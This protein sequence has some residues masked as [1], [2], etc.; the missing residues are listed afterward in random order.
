MM[1]CLSHLCACMY[2]CAQDLSSS[3][4]LQLRIYSAPPACAGA[5]ERR[6]RCKC[7]RR[8]VC[9]CMCESLETD[10]CTYVAHETNRPLGQYAMKFTNKIGSRRCWHKTCTFPCLLKRPCVTSPDK[11]TGDRRPVT[12]AHLQTPSKHPCGTSLWAMAQLCAVLPVFQRRTKTLLPQPGGHYMHTVATM[13]L[14]N[15]A[16]IAAAN[17]TGIW[18]C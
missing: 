1:S 16:I 17:V 18:R 9:T 7:H 6:Q 4:Q 12:A 2:Q 13:P 14:L 8:G 10:V 15:G 11:V 3:W 5:R